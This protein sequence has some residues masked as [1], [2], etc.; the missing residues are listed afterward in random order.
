MSVGKICVREVDTAE[1]GELV[2]AAAQRMRGRRVGTL[3]VLD[4]LGQP[5]GIVTDRDLTIRVLAASLEPNQ[6][7]VQDVMTKTPRTVREDAPIEDALALM[8]SGRFRRVPVVDANNKLVGLLSL[9]DIL[10]L[11]AEEFRDIGG[12]LRRESPHAPGVE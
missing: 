3:V 2:R 1:P 5:I 4:D 12:L 9:D 11:L 7:R 6:T 10:G 8:R